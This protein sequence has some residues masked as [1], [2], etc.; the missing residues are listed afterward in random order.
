MKETTAIKNKKA[1]FEFQLLESYAAGIQLTGTEIKSIRSGK[2]NLSDSYCVFENGEL[3][4]KNMYISEYKEGSYNNVEP[5]R[6]RKL[7]L[8]KKELHKLNQKVK[9]KGLT[10]IPVKLFMNERGF[11]K[12]EIALARGKKFHDK[13]EDLKLKDARREMR[14]HKR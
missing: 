13:R 6:Q 4:V 10:I 14:E 5:K 1:G 11:A 9:V 8:T 3:W 2:A 12:L 7:L